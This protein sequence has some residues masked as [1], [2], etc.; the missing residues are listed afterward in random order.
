MSKVPK[1]FSRLDVASHNEPD[2][3]WLII[4]NEVYNVTD[5]QNTNPGGQKSKPS[6]LATAVD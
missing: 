2:D 3:L 1:T 6:P 5:F 4:S